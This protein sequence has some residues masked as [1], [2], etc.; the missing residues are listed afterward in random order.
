MA[1]R[2]L[3]GEGAQG[4]K[5]RRRRRGG[6]RGCGRPPTA[7]AFK[8]TASELFKVPLGTFRPANNSDAVS[9][10]NHVKRVDAVNLGKPLYE[11]IAE[12][13]AEAS[14]VSAPGAGGDG[15]SGRPGLEVPAEAS[16]AALL[17]ARSAET[18]SNSASVSAELEASA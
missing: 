13:E 18:N 5:G 15:Q 16:G 17:S 14:T 1:S 6:F 9:F 12:L 11:V 4:R 2:T 10:R 3:V 8:S 7:S